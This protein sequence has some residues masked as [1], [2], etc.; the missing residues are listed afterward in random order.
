MSRR[1]PGPLGS[2]ILTAGVES[3]AARRHGA[4]VK[5]YPIRAGVILVALAG[6]ALS[7]STARAQEGVRVRPLL[8][9]R[10]GP[11]V[12]AGILPTGWRG[13]WPVLQ[14]PAGAL[15]VNPATGEG[16]WVGAPASAPVVP[17]G[18]RATVEAPSALGFGDGARLFVSPNAL[19]LE[20]PSAGSGT[21]GAPGSPGALPTVRPL[22]KTTQWELRQVERLGDEVFVVG[23]RGGWGVSLLRL[24]GDRLRW[25]RELG[26]GEVGV[27]SD[28]RALWIRTRVDFRDELVRFDPPN[29]TQ[30]VPLDGAVLGCVATVRGRAVLMTDGGLFRLPEAGVAPRTRLGPEDAR[31]SFPCAF[32]T[33]EDALWP[34]VSR[35]RLV[36]DG[37]PEGTFAFEADDA[38]EADGAELLAVLGSEYAAFRERSGIAVVRRDGEVVAR[39]EDATEVRSSGG[40]LFAFSTLPAEEGRSPPSVVY[41][42]VPGGAFERWGDTFE[43]PGSWL[44]HPEVAR[45]GAV[46]LVRPSGST[47]EQDG[48]RAPVLVHLGPDGQERGRWPVPYG[49]L[50][51]ERVPFTPLGRSQAMA[52]L[53][54]GEVA[55]GPE[56]E[57]FVVVDPSSGEVRL[58]RLDRRLIS[59][60][61]ERVYWRMPVEPGS[62]RFEDEAEL[63]SWSA[64][65][66]EVRV[67]TVWG[68]AFGSP[69]VGGRPFIAH[70]WS[71]LGTDPFFQVDASNALAAVF[72]E[73]GVDAGLSIQVRDD[74][75]WRL[76]LLGD[77]WDVSRWDFERGAPERVDAVIVDEEA[78]PRAG[79]LVLGRTPTAWLVRTQSL[80]EGG[81]TLR[82]MR[83][84]DGSS[85]LEL[86]GGAYPATPRGFPEARP[87]G[88]EYGG[89]V[90]LMEGEA[91]AELRG[92]AFVGDSAASPFG[93]VVSAE[94]V[95]ASEANVEGE[96][97]VVAGGLPGGAAPGQG[98]RGV[99]PWVARGTVDQANPEL[100]PLGDLFPGPEGSNPQAFAALPDGSGVVFHALSPDRG[101]ELWFW[102]GTDAEARP[103][104]DLAPGPEPGIPEQATIVIGPELAFV[105]AFV[106]DVGTEVVAIPLA[107]VRGEVAC[108][109]E[110]EVGG[111]EGGGDLQAADSGCGCSGTRSEP[112]PLALWVLL[113]LC[114]AACRV[115]GH[116][117]RRRARHRAGASAG[118][119]PR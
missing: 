59:S 22:V 77:T 28:G 106:P 17:R 91:L 93:L 35:P 11:P 58:E 88:F 4:A 14:L 82:L 37:T 117:R 34:E 15:A 50:E 52:A 69:G 84:T 62:G 111:V 32:V 70:A 7:P 118:R 30:P 90:L 43:G 54:S 19:W 71:R 2:G 72:P 27:V 112:K 89:R 101:R 100:Q 31:V 38:F 9:L 65:G 41:R 48:R 40:A 108:V 24:D 119:V 49:A 115:S 86:P 42:F 25:V 67:G 57:G 104:C 21:P 36:T 55:L 8:D 78:E 83:V 116:H 47:P 103:V 20:E 66:G 61:G 51:S 64:S 110:S 29:T 53:D 113:A 26:R 18:V 39:L 16:V 74:G 96:P 85:T 63:W 99:E 33:A 6:L 87:E 3:T 79:L 68:N 56:F 107:A 114:A 92:L 105:A 75:I 97:P 1:G 73:V 81:G 10:P 80:F 12:P 13:D 60:D 94:D 5:S 44:P 98:A 76:R 46:L 23:R 109:R 45:G 95:P 102:D